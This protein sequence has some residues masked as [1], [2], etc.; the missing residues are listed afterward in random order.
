[1]TSSSSDNFVQTINAMVLDI[2]PAKVQ[3]ERDLETVEYD[4]YRSASELAVLGEV[5]SARDLVNVLYEE[6]APIGQFG[7]ADRRL[8]VAWKATGKIPDGL[9]SQKVQEEADN[10]KESY[11]VSPENFFVCTIHGPKDGRVECVSEAIQEV[12]FDANYLEEC[13]ATIRQNTGSTYPIDTIVKALTISLALNSHDQLGTTSLRS[14]ARVPKTISDLSHRLR[15]SDLDATSIELVRMVATGWGRRMIDALMAVEQ[16]WPY[17]NR[18]LLADAVGISAEKLRSRAEDLI[19]A[20]SARL[21]HGY[22]ENGLESKSLKELLEIGETNTL[23]GPGVRHWEEMGGDIPETMFKPPA[24]SEQISQLESRLGTNLPEDYKEFLGITNGFVSDDS[25]QDGVFNGYFPDP[26]LF[27]TDE[28]EWLSEDWL[29]LPFEMLK[30]PRE[31][32]DPYRKPSEAWDTAMPFLD[33][34]V[35]VGNRDI[36]DLWL[37]HPDLVQKAKR[38]YLEMLENGNEMHKK[39]L[40]RAMKEFAG[41]MERFMELEWCCVKNSS[42]GAAATEVFSSFRSYVES[43]VGESGED[44]MSP[45]ARSWYSD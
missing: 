29:A 39:I 6:G 27:S 3:R 2:D 44:K 21:S 45:A 12:T 32:E 40:Q 10:V 13:L 11:E 34:V 28:V 23:T 24:T 8:K 35:Y 15:V 38:A 42:G 36:D 4:L 43:V 14:G 20:F 22:V 17:Y 25:M 30:I 9:S 26:A 5:E 1:M 37:V 19:R 41:S 18:G 7:W 33:R 16:L 31:I